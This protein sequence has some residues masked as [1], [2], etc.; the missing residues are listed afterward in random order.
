MTQTGQFTDGPVLGVETSCDETSAAVL[1]GSRLAGHVILSQDAHERFGG[2]VPEIAARAHLRQID[3]VVTATLAEAGVRAGEIDGVGVTAGP[4][5]IGALLVGLNWAKGFAYALGRPLVGVHH[6]EAH[7]YAHSV[8]APEV[9][10]PFV[11]LLVS[12]G[13][14]MLIHAIGWENY[15]LLGE[16]RDDAVGEAFDKVA[17]TFGFGFPGGPEIERAAREGHPGH[18]RLPRPMLASTDHPGDP[19]YFD[20]SFSGLKT[21]AALLAADLTTA[22]GSARL[23]QARPD[24]AAEFQEA[25][26]DVL[27]AKTRRAVEYTGCTR[28]VLGGGV[29]RNG[30]LR[31]R[32]ASEM[33]GLADVHAPPP[34]LATDNAAMVAC[35]ARHRLLAGKR[36]DLSLNADP[37]Y[38]FP[39]LV[40]NILQ[41][42]TCIRN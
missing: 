2:I 35:V 3:D 12:G 26:L 29:S 1:V 24:L 16:T 32:L 33:A 31:E 9:E 28:V 17:R 39:G 11:A 27:V 36:A 25:V 5:L 15:R 34:R 13:H 8:G 40:P 38:P 18:F 14:T 22:G 37:A 42:T 20:F 4:G 30:R 41:G 21:A 19:A 23:E 6:M 10:P 7:L